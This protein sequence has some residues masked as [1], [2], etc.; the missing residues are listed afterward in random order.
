MGID[1]VVL[2]GLIYRSERG[3]LR[4]TRESHTS[5]AG[6]PSVWNLLMIEGCAAAAVGDEIER[7]KSFPLCS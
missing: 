3:I 2:P 7:P 1:E 6:K 4:N 5:F